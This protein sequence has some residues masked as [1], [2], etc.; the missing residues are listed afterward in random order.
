[1]P[2]IRLAAAAAF[3]LA[4][5][6]ALAPA[7]AAAPPV[8]VDALG[9]FLPSYT[10]PRQADLDVVTALTF[11]DTTSGLFSF[12]ATMAGAIGT[13]A[14]AAYVWGIDR[15]AGVQGFPTLA[16]GVLFDSVLFV[17]AS[18]S[19]G[20]IDLLSGAFTPVAGGQV[21]GRTL[22]VDLAAAAMAPTTFTGLAPEQYTWNLWPR[23]TFDPSND[24]TISDFAPD[25]SN[26]GVI[27][28]SSVPEPASW[29][30]LAAGLPLLAARVRRRRQR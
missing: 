27:V 21:A 22:S 15:G 8:A 20:F 9:D 12:S 24:A 17:D 11:Y 3:V 18:G 14:G 6:G 5:S 13:T 10:G 25:N 26:L 19:G 7:H 4:A 2:S 30:A 23:N 29:L 16:P 28:V 1:M